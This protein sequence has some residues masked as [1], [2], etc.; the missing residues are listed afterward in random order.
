MPIGVAIRSIVKTH[1]STLNAQ[2]STF[3]TR[4]AFRLA[5]VLLV[6]LAWCNLA[7]CDIFGDASM[8]NLD[9]VRWALKDHP[10]LVNSRNSEGDT[11]LHWAAGGDQPEIAELLLTNK[12]DVNARNNNG[13]TPLHSAAENGATDVAELLLTNGADINARDKEGETPLHLALVYK[14]PA[15]RE[16]LL[17]N[18]GVN[19]DDATT[20]QNS[21]DDLGIVKILL[22]ANPDLIRSGDNSGRTPLDIAADEGRIDVV[23]FLMAYNPDVN[24]VD[25]RPPFEGWTPLFFAVNR[26]QEDMAEKM[27]DNEVE[28]L[29]ESHRGPLRQA[30]SPEATHDGK[31]YV[32]EFLLTHGANV[33]VAASD[34]T[35]PLLAAVK[36]SDREMVELLLTNK[37]NIS[38]TNNEGEMPLFLAARNEDEGIAEMLMAH[39]AD[40]N[41]KSTFMRDTI[42]QMPLH[43]AA[44][45]GHK[46]VVALLLAH[47]AEI[48][49]TTSYGW[50]P[51]HFAVY[52][53]HNDVADLLRLRGGI[54]DTNPVPKYLWMHGPL[55]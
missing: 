7:R 40:V 30:L 29:V 11:P 53:K 32:A 1:L 39:G 23:T 9:D 44:A 10:D 3:F 41:G 33:N 8:G 25:D 46:D 19:M 49:A 27:L 26:R 36:N 48:N 38:V 18:G 54:C 45:A 31:K 12:A 55:P 2:C 50:T 14:H 5:A 6:A 13:Y 15:M 35:T 17:K 24:A 20:I 34:G 22:K 52:Y 21:I 4:P 47:G 43:A 42:G 51:L 28:M 37:A 16:F